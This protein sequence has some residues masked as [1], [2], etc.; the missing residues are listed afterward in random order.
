MKLASVH[1]TFLELSWLIKDYHFCHII[2]T[3]HA[4]QLSMPYF[5]ATI[6]YFSPY[7]CTICFS[8]FFSFF[9]KL[10]HHCFQFIFHINFSY[11][12]TCKSSKVNVV[13]IKVAVVVIFPGTIGKIHAMDTIQH[14]IGYDGQLAWHELIQS[15]NAVWQQASF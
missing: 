5:Q 2:F 15:L 7:Y 6:F 13:D 12:A 8:L 1:A 3:I 9:Q 10:F 14:L 11:T 4:T